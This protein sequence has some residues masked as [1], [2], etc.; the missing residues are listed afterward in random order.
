MDIS[1]I[2]TRSLTRLLALT[3]KKEELLQI[4]DQIDA[5]I[6]E[7]LRGGASVEVI[8][9]ANAT[10]TPTLKPPTKA[11]PSAAKPVKAGKRGGV[12][13]RI[14]ALLE[15]AGS[16]GL[17][18]REI[19]DKLGAKPANISVWFST[20]GKNL[21]TKLEPGLYAVKGA[22][23]APAKVAA[24]VAAKAPAAKPAKKKSKM[25]AAGRAR[26]AAAMK[27]RWA[28]HRAGKSP[29]PTTKSAEKGKKAQ[30]NPF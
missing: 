2:N 25:S 12:K 22:K 16:Q 15:A 4:V 10:T 18:A 24:P 6:I 7:T 28:A 30:K 1:L 11:K 20:T 3:E 26:I 8:K 9:F 21:V 23:S 14:L 27:A 19:A 5:S 17:R 29:A 13:N